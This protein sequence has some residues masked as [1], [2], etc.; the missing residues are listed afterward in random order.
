MDVALVIPWRD[1]GSEHRRVNCEWL[2]EHYRSAGL[3]VIVADDGHE[4]GPFNRS[5]AF[6]RGLAEAGDPDVTIWNEADCLIPMDQLETAAML[7]ARAPGLVV[8]YTDRVELTKRGAELLRTDLDY[9]PG[10]EHVERVFS[11]GT[12]IGQCGVTS[13]ATMQAVGQWDE[14]FAGWGFDDNAMFL[15][16]E[17]LAGPPRWVQGVGW[18]LWH[19]LAY[20]RVDTDAKA[21]TAANRARYQ[22]M[23]ATQD[24][25]ALRALICEP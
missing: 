4:S 20:G 17:R 22:A 15:A 3:R 19:P 8:P 21:R 13:R 18:H 7:A 10:P 12:S 16:F 2:V 14:H 11:D 6:N 9:W 25:A 23:V 1:G 24:P 5:A